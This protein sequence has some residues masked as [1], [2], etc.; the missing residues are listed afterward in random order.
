[1]AEVISPNELA[2]ELE[3]KVAE[4][5]SAEVQL[6]WVIDPEQR[7]VRIHRADGTFGW[8]REGDTLS[9]ET[10]L[11]GFSCPVRDLFPR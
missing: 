8:L 9:G 11:P 10:I 2:S 5:L 3:A 7:T 1:V 6:V 4:F